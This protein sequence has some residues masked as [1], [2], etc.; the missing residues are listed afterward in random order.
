MS[1]SEFQHD[2]QAAS[3]RWLRTLTDALPQMVWVSRAYD[4]VTIYANARFEAIFGTQGDTCADHI[5][6]H[7]PDDRQRVADDWATAVAAGDRFEVEARLRSPDGGHRWHKIVIV[8]IR[9]EGTVV[10]WLGTALDIEQIV[11]ARQDVQRSEERLA[12]ALNA[13]S[14]GFVDCDLISGRAWVSDRYWAMLGYAPGEIEAHAS[15]WRALLHP[16]EEADV[17]QRLHAHYEG[18]E[19]LFECEH[20]LQR[21]DGSWGW[22]LTR[23]CVVARDTDGL[24]LRYVGIHMDI[25]VRKA[26][27]LKVAHMA[28]HDALTGLA[29]RIL[30]HERLERRLIKLERD[31]RAFALLYLDLDR[32]KLVN[33]TLGHAAGDA[34]LREVAHRMREVLRSWDVI[35]RLGGD[36]FAILLDRAHDEQ[37]AAGVAERLLATMAAP[38]HLAGQSIQ[39]SLSIGLAIAPLHGRDADTLL[40]CADVALYR[41][42][43]EGRGTCRT[44]TSVS[45]LNPA[46]RLPRH[47][48]TRDL[49]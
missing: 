26:T 40:A 47:L 43:L 24:P 16:S 41:A 7:H 25:G 22:F 37:A 30:F 29:N 5:A 2:T 23:G 42:K 35:A 49:R 38:V 4:G 21:K 36:E 18:V 44:Y 33:D 3:D 11:S 10:E 27:E 15:T 48:T 46:Q 31:G 39:V 13:A 8:P 17:M 6:A 1:R 20:R 9:R 14:D 45:S 19:P 28:S 34:L 32:F 12:H